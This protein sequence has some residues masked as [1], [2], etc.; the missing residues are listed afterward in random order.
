MHLQLLLVIHRD[1]LIKVHRQLLLDTKQVIINK[2]QI[3]L[4]L[5]INVDYQHREPTQLQLV[6]NV[7]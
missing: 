1:N 4:Q 3:V 2:E 5:D 7:V 6:I